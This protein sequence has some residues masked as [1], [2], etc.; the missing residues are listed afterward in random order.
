MRMRGPRPVRHGKDAASGDG[1][2]Q[3][4][5][6]ASRRPGEF[7]ILLALAFAAFMTCLDNTVVNVALPRIQQSLRLDLP[8]LEWVAAA[9][10]LTFAALL[11]T[12]GRSADIWG[13]RPTLLTGLALFTAA[14]LL[15][16]LARSG[17]VLIAF[18]GLQG[19]GA[20]LVMPASLAVLARDLGPRA[21]AAGIAVWMSALALA[22]ALG[23]VLGGL[24]SQ[25]WGWGWIFAINVPFG[26]LAAV[27]VARALPRGGRTV[28]GRGLVRAVALAGRF[29][30]LGT[31]LSCLAAGACAFGLI[32][33]VRLGLVPAV[34]VFAAS[35][36]ALALFVWRQHAA[37]TPMVDLTLFR[38]RVFAGGLA[39]QVL[40]GLGVNGVL[41]LTALFL[42]R[43][44]GLTPTEAGLA[45]TP[46][47][48]FLIL[49][50]PLV[51]VL[52]RV[53]GAH[54]A[55]AGG[56]LTVAAGLLALARVGAGASPL[57]LL[58]GLVAIGAG[59]ALTVPLTERTLDASPDEV[60]G[61]TS[62]VV[63]AAREFA[64]LLGIAVL[65]AIVAHRQNTESDSKGASA[66]FVEGYQSGLLVA[67]VFVAI[68]A[69][70]AAVSLR[71][72]PLAESRKNDG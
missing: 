13:R 29:D 26:V 68:G 22:L 41:F 56:L 70:V 64:G 12:G 43:V 25:H 23:P 21:R 2:G 59:S 48:L 67:S 49:A 63:S 24:I 31:G 54:R 52:V 3:G 60:S 5:E 27:T 55:C 33:G 69:V 18:R 9:Y 8:D 65:G 57:D 51:P 44:L 62:G 11:L 38:D 36:L 71:P 53:L 40:W 34:A 39:A 35:A 42:Q 37:R 14:S 58:P 30:P 45:F 61:A 66:A 1:R 46:V 50:T 6:S 16:G 4:V 7:G 10:P 72:A 28:P 19:V 15:C 20:A 17:P 47:A 32:E